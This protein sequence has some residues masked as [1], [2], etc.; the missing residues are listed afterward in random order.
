VV[1]GIAVG[2]RDPEDPINTARSERAPLSEVVKWR[3]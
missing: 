2:Y 3:E 1:V